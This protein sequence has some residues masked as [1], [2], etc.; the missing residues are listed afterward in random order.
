MK[1]L[2]PKEELRARVT[3]SEVTGSRFP[4]SV[5]GEYVASFHQMGLGAMV[6][7]DG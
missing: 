6:R 1:N 7:P 3:Q 2:I 4:I 5:N